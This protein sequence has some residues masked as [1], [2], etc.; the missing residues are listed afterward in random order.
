MPLHDWTRIPACLF[1][2][3]HQDWS[4]EI[5]RELNRG[6]L[7]HGLSALVEQRSGP[8][9]SDVLA[10]EKAGGVARFGLDPGGATATAEPPA[11]RLVRRS[12]KQPYASRANRIVVRHHLGRIVAI[13]E[14][15]SP[16]NKDSRAALRDFVEK[17]IG[18]LRAG[19]H[20]LIVDLFP[21]T[22]R[23]PFGIHKAIWDEIEEEDFT[24]PAGK[25]RTVVS[26]Q[27][28]SECV[29]YIEPLA[30]G[31]ELPDMALFLA[32]DLHVMTPLEA[33]YQ[34]A[35]AASPEALRVAVET[36]VVPDPDAD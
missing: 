18:F 26:Y 25:D 1:H 2:H 16:G 17:T 15:V 3:F 31:D 14:I 28:G 22:P 32:G 36:G 11:T 35:W 34:V 33:T 8:V 29:A 6:R 7:P 10:I 24:F 27:A 30:V 12:T 23:D 5:A 4:I 19:I 13:M 9:E 20:L 21:P